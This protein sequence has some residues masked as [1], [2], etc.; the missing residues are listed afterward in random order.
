MPLAVTVARKNRNSSAS[1]GER[2]CAWDFGME[3]ET[4]MEM[5]KRRYEQMRQAHRLPGSIRKQ[6]SEGWGVELGA[7]YREAQDHHHASGQV[8]V[9]V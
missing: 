2:V 8:H 1:G 6:V 5:I 7:Q 3:G 4:R 9:V